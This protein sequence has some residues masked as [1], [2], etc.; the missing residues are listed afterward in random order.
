LFEKR[1]MLQ[2]EGQNDRS[3]DVEEGGGEEG[4]GQ[5]DPNNKSCY[6]PMMEKAQPIVAKIQP[7]VQKAA[8]N[9]S[10]FFTDDEDEV[11]TEETVSGETQEK[12]MIRVTP[13]VFGAAFVGM[14]VGTIIAGPIIGLAMA[15]GAS[16]AR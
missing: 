13:T 12:T 9:I 2:E 11:M 4:S 6:A 5:Y 14:A 10:E 16:Y 8:T 15:G 7:V 1:I 3:V